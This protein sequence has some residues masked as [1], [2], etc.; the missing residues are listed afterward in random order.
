MSVT[1]GARFGAF[2]VAES[3]GSGGMGEVYRARDSRLRRDVA[4][5]VLPAGHRLDPDR[6]ARFEREALAL[7]ALYHPNIA[8]IHGIEQIGD[9]QGLVMELVDGPTLADRLD[10]A[11]PP[12]STREQSGQ[13]GGTRR[14]AGLPVGETIAIARQI[15]DAREA[16]HERGVIHRDL[17]PS[18]IKIRPDGVVKILDFG[19]AKALEADVGD[20]TA[21]P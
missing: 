20:L 21:R 10:R 17:K 11:A 5:K 12:Q 18:N 14:P 15:V 19:L 8:T 7:A 6:Q 16:A 2:I 1:S 3:L 13:A 4:L 9:V